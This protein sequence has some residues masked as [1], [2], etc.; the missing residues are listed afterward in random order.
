MHWRKQRDIIMHKLYGNNIRLTRGDTLA[1]A[2]GLWNADGTEYTPNAGDVIRFALKQDYAQD[3]P[4]LNIIIPND[5]Q[6]LTI[7]PNDTK[8]L[9]FGNYVYDIELTKED[10]TVDT[11]IA[12]ATFT[13]APEVH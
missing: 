10:G 2:V 7:N 11:F 9:A 6:I 8:D 12:E 5:T 4:I 1:V 3:T 13:V